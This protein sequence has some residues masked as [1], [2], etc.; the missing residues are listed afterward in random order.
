MNFA[1]ALRLSTAVLILTLIAVSA[2]ADQAQDNLACPAEQPV[3]LPEGTNIALSES[4]RAAYTGTLRI[5]IVEP[6]SRWYAYDNRKYEM[7]FL[8]FATVEPLNL[9]TDEVYQNTYYWSGATNGWLVYD[10]NIMAIAVVFTSQGQTADAYPPNGYFFTAYYADAAAGAEPDQIAESYVGGSWTHS[11]FV[12]EATATWCQY[13]PGVRD[14]LK[15]IY[16]NAAYHMFFVALVDDRNVNAHNRI[17]GDMSI[18]AWPTAYFDAGDEVV[19]GNQATS[20]FT[21]ATTTAGTRANNGIQL[22]TGVEWIGNSELLIRVAIGNDVAPNNAPTDPLIVEGVPSTYADS[23]CLFVG[24]ASDVDAGELF[25]QWDWGNGYQ[26]DWYGPFDAAVPCSLTY[27][28]PDDGNFDVTMRAR[29]YWG[30][31]T[32]WTSAYAVEVLPNTCCRGDSR[33]NLDGDALN[34]VTLGDLTVMIDLLFISLTPPNCWDEANLDGSLPEG[35]GSVTLGDL[36]VLID[37][38]FISLSPLPPCP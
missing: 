18:G 22:M 29:D 2:F 24:S 23:S 21:S 10:T 1:N 9:A 16:D 15:Q 32:S 25:Y 14:K 30:E 5:Y 36:T 31:T 27:A 11:A 26:S 35:P 37:N 19:V 28:F 7:G 17:Y 13:C 20:Y 6:T 8:E 3:I 33:G 38:L 34:A 4:D 12:E